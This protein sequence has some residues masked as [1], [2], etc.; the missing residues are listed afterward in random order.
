L[1]TFA[2]IAAVLIAGYAAL[3]FTYPSN[4]W[5]YRLTI[6]MET[7]EG[8][9]TGVSVYQIAV[10]TGMGFGDSSGAHMYA[11]GEALVVD[12]GTRGILFAL[13]INDQEVDYNGY[14]V[15]K[16]FPYPGPKQGPLSGVATP[17]GL[18][19][20]SNLRAKAELAPSQLPTLVRFRDTNDPK[21][22]ELVDANDLAKSFGAGVRFK[23]ATIEMVDAGVWP[24]SMFGITGE[25]V[26]RG[27]ETRLV[28]LD[29]EAQLS[30]F[31][32]SLYSRGFQSNGS[33]EV[34][35]LFI[36]GR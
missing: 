26:T 34:R 11:K 16:T 19:Y 15:F 7:P 24:F 17:A 4:S 6:N 36:Q 10:S 18:K 35:A 2:L 13:M 21:T 20:Y 32:K 9:K 3:H 14:L 25:P 22:V 31:W 1:K 28:W 23:S 27:I 8:I 30:A 5:R 33:I 29:D 12:L